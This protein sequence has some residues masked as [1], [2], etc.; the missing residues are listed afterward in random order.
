MD[1][2]HI[3]CDAHFKIVFVRAIFGQKDTRK[4]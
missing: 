1:L 2:T 4:V 3:G